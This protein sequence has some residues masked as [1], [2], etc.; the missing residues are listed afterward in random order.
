MNGEY[1]EVIGCMNSW[2]I[3]MKG[4]MRKMMIF[5]MSM[6]RCCDRPVRWSIRQKRSERV[7]L[8]AI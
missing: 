7:T 3:I 4:L 6:K 8:A 1:E 2:R 5:R